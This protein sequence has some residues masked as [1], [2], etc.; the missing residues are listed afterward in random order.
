MITDW[1]TNKI[2]LG[3]ADIIAEYISAFPILIGVSI[4]VYALVAM[5]SKS[6]ARIAVYI[7]FLY[8][9]LIVLF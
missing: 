1:I 8:G 4:A 7:V 9:F 3:I 6:F 5:I 2:K